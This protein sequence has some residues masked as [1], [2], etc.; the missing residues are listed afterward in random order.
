[1][2]IVDEEGFAV[3]SENDDIIA[4]IQANVN[5]EVVLQCIEAPGL[6]ENR[7]DPD[8]CIKEIPSGDLSMWEDRSEGRFKRK[9]HGLNTLFKS[10]VHKVI[11][12]DGRTAHPVTDALNG[13]GTIIS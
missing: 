6:L 1:M 3:N 13:K 5:A 11:I 8:S 2:P 10:G 9:L 7:D 12:A 4:V